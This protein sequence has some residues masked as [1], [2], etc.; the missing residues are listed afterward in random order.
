MHFLCESR[1][2]VVSLSWGRENSFPFCSVWNFEVVEQRQVERE[3]NHAFSLQ[4]SRAV[5][6]SGR[7]EGTW[8]FGCGGVLGFVLLQSQARQPYQ[9]VPLLEVCVG[10][11]VE[12]NKLDS[13]CS[14][15]VLAVAVGL[16]TSRGCLCSGQ[17][18]ALMTL[19]FR[20]RALERLE[21]KHLLC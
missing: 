8:A 3:A 18:T 15:V 9:P 2:V 16:I 13:L 4:F 14:C 12:S 17:C 11:L 5:A 6:R 10:L 20:F 7:V 21:K 1:R 19:P